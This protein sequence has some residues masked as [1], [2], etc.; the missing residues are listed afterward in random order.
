MKDSFPSTLSQ[1]L[2]VELNGFLVKNVFKSFALKK[3][4][5]WC[6]NPS[7][8]MKKEARK[9]ERNLSVQETVKE[10]FSDPKISQCFDRQF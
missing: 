6:V 9:K 10:L 8:E 5:V 3:T 4:P 1:T 7:A 2:V